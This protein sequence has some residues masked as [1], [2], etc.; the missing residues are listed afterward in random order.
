MK[1]AR[2]TEMRRADLSSSIHLGIPYLS[3]ATDGEATWR[4]GVPCPCFSPVGIAQKTSSIS[5]GDPAFSEC[6]SSCLA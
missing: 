2:P 1:K 5:S 4:C 3:P 6:E